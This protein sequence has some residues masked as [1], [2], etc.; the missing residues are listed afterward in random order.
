M[1][2]FLVIFF[3]VYAFVNLYFYR[4]LVSGFAF[5]TALRLPLALF[6]GFMV[7]SPAVWRYLDRSGFQEISSWVA[8]LSLMWM[9][10]VIYF[11]LV[12]LVLDLVSRFRPLSPKARSLASL[13]ISLFLSLY[14][15]L[16]TYYLQ[17]YRFSL[18]T[19]KLP[20]GE[21]IKILHISDLHLGPLMG[22]DRV[23]MVLRVYREE[24][25]HMVVATGDTVDGNMTGRDG[26]ADM[27][28]SMEPPLG[29]YAVLGNHEF[30]RGQEQAVNFLR[31]A[32]FKVLRCGWEEV[33]D[34]LV[35]AGV[36]DPAGGGGCD[37]SKALTGVDTSK[38]VILLKHRP[39]VN[40]ETLDLI[41]LQISG[42]SHGGV[43][44]FVGYTLLRLLYETDRGMK[45][46]SPGKFIVVSKGV[47]TGGPPMRL[48][49]PPDVV[50][51]TLYCKGSCKRR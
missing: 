8:F 40:R 47:G 50:V 43:L 2:P 30:Y 16:E 26:L 37:E 5:K 46:I 48:L 17:V 11:L 36:D 33:G 51:I 29:K 4:K 23:A 35:V 12:G 41:D 25:P 49:S 10:F 9:G 7:L 24:R 45:E 22:E 42:H 19:P 14:S 34:Y 31:R 20:E 28:R 18:N 13:L 44:F 21:S 6:L 15:H 32:G 3:T 39:S 38:F 27:L 1:F